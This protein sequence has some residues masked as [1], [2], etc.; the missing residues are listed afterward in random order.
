MRR[1][2]INI[3]LDNPC[4]ERNDFCVNCHSQFMAIRPLVKGVV[5]S[6][7]FIKD[8]KDTE[9]TNFIINSIL[10][11]SHLEFNELHKFEE[12]VDGN[13]IFRAR[14]EDLHI[15]YCVDKKMKMIFLRAIKNFREYKKFLE[16][17]KELRRMIERLSAST[18]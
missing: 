15:V 13:L 1:M 4:G 2:D 7:R 8:L 10:D 14:K 12:N 9:K 17:T 3:R 18:D 6:K 16:D 5:V 11:C